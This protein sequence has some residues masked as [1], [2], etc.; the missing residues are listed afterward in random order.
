MAPKSL[1]PTASSSTLDIPTTG[2][3]RL[4]PAARS[5]DALGRNH[6]LEAALAELVDNAIDAGAKAVVIRF[7]LEDGQLARVVVADDGGGMNELDIDV[8]M[9]VGGER[10]YEEGEIGRFGFGL[11]AASFS[12]ADSLT[13]L[14]RKAGEAAVGRRLVLGDVRTDFL[15]DIISPRYAAAALKDDDVCAKGF[16]TIIRWETV[17]GFPVE[18]DADELDR[19]VQAAARR[20]ATSLGLLF[21]RFIADG[22]IYIRLEVVEDDEPVGGVDVQPLDPFAHPRSGAVGWPKKLT[23]NR[24]HSMS[25]H[26]WPARSNLDEFRLDGDLMARQGLYVYLNDRLVQTGGWCALVHPDK[27]LNIGRVSL[28]ITGDLPQ[29]LAVRPEK[30]GIEPGPR[31]E[32][33]LRAAKA[34]DGSTL[35]DCWDAA[36]NVTKEANNRVRGRP[37]KVLLG[38]GFDPKIRRAAKA[39]LTPRGGSPISI[40]WK[41]LP[42]EVFFDIHRSDRVLYLNSRYRR[43]LAGKGRLND[44]PVIKTLLYLLFEDIFAGQNLGP[45]DKDNL[46]LWQALLSIAVAVESGNP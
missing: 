46:E 41:R 28:D 7:V 4:P 10:A 6:T 12:Q 9:T 18:T 13:V 11:K 24:H 16:G 31:F 23:I 38:Q 5:I 39:E 42:E 8:A 14:S 22:R 1:K 19:F 32:K 37:P 43:V 27:R 3:V 20:V 21:H 44:V 25:C 30:N 34:R 33:L 45:R 29:I 2:T 36:R 40:L 15:C 17:R 35:E 26:I